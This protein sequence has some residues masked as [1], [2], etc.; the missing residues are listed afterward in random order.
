MQAEKL[1]TTLTHAIKDS[2]I[3]YSLLGQNPK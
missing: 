1:T 3:L 2:Q